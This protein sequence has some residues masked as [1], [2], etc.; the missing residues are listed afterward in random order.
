MYTVYQYIIVYLYMVFADTFRGSKG[1]RDERQHLLPEPL[2][3]LHCASAQL[4]RCL[5]EGSG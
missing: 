3:G 1:H 5:R 2:S 4:P